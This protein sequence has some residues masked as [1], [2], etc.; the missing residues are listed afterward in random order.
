MF[1]Y[2]GMDNALTLEAKGRRSQ[3]RSTEGR[4]EGKESHNLFNAF[5]RGKIYED[6]KF[7]GGVV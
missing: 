6:R 2:F 4:S 5:V 1:L 3:H 7:Q